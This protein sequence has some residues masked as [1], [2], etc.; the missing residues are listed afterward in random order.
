[1]QRLCRPLGN[2]WATSALRLDAPYDGLIDSIYRACAHD[3]SV[4]CVARN[5]GS[6]MRRGSHTT[7]QRWGT[8]CG[9]GQRREGAGS[10]DELTTTRHRADRDR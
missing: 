6:H 9:T 5:R 3:E 8:G 2:C 10:Q 7:P 1:M 4:C